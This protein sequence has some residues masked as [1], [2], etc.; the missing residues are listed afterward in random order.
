[1]GNFCVQLSLCSLDKKQANLPT[2]AVES[3]SVH[4]LWLPFIEAALGV[5]RENYAAQLGTIKAYERPLGSY[6][7]LLFN[8]LL[9]NGCQLSDQLFVSSLDNTMRMRAAQ[10]FATTLQ[11]HQGNA[12]GRRYGERDRLALTIGELQRNLYLE[13]DWQQQSSSL[14]VGQLINVS[15]I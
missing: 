5:C 6:Y 2:V 8:V 15:G 9:D 3:P 7:V 11:A 13:L 12:L 14:Q 10:R 4:D 1:V